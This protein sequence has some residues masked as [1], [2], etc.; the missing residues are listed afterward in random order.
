MS[1]ILLALLFP[2]FVFTNCSKNFNQEEQ[3]FRET[4][5]TPTTGEF[6]YNNKDS[7]IY[8]CQIMKLFTEPC[9]INQNSFDI[10]RLI[11]YVPRNYNY[12]FRISKIGDCFLL[13]MKKVP[14]NLLNMINF[15]VL[16]RVVAYNYVGVRIGSESV[17]EIF[18]S[19]DRTDSMS[20]SKKESDIFKEYTLEYYNNNKYN[21]VYSDNLVSLNFSFLE[22]KLMNYFPKDDGELY[23]KS[24]IR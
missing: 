10:F 2:I 8:E 13:H 20:N 19:I 17:D 12:I 21:I 14:P 16:D 6:D 22:N 15:Q 18:R 24:K 9:S 23:G 7:L 11:I 1:R 5:C 4:F 3:L